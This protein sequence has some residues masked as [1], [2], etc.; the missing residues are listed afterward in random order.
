MAKTSS[1]I[2]L[3]YSLTKSEKRYF[4]LFTNLQ[5][6]DKN[7]LKLLTLIETLPQ[8]SPASLK[9]EF[10]SLYPGASFEIAGKHLYNI[11]M[12]SLLH[13]K[14]AEDD[15]IIKM[16]TSVC[17]I[18][19]LFEKALYEEAFKESERLQ[20]FAADHGHE[21]MLM[22]AIKQEIHFR[23]LLNFE[24]MSEKELIHNQI[25]ISSLLKAIS[26]AHQHQSL[27]D[28][29]KHRLIHKGSI[30]TAKQKEEL[31]DLLMCEMGITSRS[32]GN[33]FETQKTHLLFQSTYYLTI[34]DYKSALKAFFELNQLFE[35]NAYLWN[36][37]IADYLSCLE[38][39]MDSLRNIKR[40]DEIEFYLEKVRNLKTNAVHHD[41]ARLRILFIYSITNVTDKGLYKEAI[42]LIKVFPDT[43]FKNAHILGINKHAE[44][45]LHT[46]LVHFGMGNVKETIKCLNHVLLSNS[47]YLRLPEYKTFKLIRLLA[48][49]ELKDYEFVKYELN[50][51]KRNLNSKDKTYK[52]EKLVFQFLNTTMANP[53][54]SKNS[55]IWNKLKPEFDKLKDD[56]FEIQ[57]LKI[58]NF[59]VWV[60]SKLRR[61]PFTQV[62]ADQWHSSGIQQE[63]TVQQPRA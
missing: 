21:L 29:L 1:L 22:T 16:N 34:S 30:R 10:C 3:V 46:S 47:M 57:L 13:L 42:E 56:R 9:K 41:V 58:F 43:L 44:I 53:V 26:Q 27:Q 4:S 59:P 18:R 48:H 51:I 19:I 11:L 37:S 55:E 5:K 8:C 12:E 14:N 33:A 23:S 2:S 49:F 54:F 20:R 24:S 35:R 62:L 25:R 52:L 7:Y 38:G 17:A 61:R 15:P 36:E 39:I 31:N 32:T 28:L 40:H 6:G 63:S 50:T 60:E 45:Y